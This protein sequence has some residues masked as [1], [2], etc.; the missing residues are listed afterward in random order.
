MS[1]LIIF[2]ST[3]GKTSFQIFFF[4]FSP[5]STHLQLVN[6][7]IVSLMSGSSYRCQRTYKG[8]RL[9]SWQIH[10]HKLEDV[11]LFLVNFL[12][13]SLLPAISTCWL[14]KQNSYQSSRELSMTYQ[15]SA[16][17]ITKFLQHLNDNSCEDDNT[18]IVNNIHQRH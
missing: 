17:V 14:Y 9:A 16:G 12:L 15:Q 1:P 3:E 2:S 10:L 11:I 8:I 13:S 6:M 7:I 18:T 4:L 5:N